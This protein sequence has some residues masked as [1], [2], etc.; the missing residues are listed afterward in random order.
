VSRV[1]RLGRWTNLV[2]A[3]VL[4]FAVWVLVVL[5]A[6]RSSLKKLWDFSPQAVFTMSPATETLLAELQ[7]QKIKVEFHTFFRPLAGGAPEDPF[8][9][10]RWQILSRLQQLTADLLREYAFL[11]GESVRVKHH[12]LQRP[13][14]ETR[15]AATKYFPTGD[16]YDMVVV[17]AGGRHKR[18]SL[19]GDLGFIDNPAWSRQ[20]KPGAPN[21]ELPTLK[22][23]KGEEALS[24]ALKSLLAQGKPVLYFLKGNN[25]HALDTDTATGDGYGSFRKAL[26][27]EG[28]ELRDLML[29]PA[30]GVPKDASLVVALEPRFEFSPR[31]AELLFAYLRRGGRLFLNY[32]YVDVD[33]WNPNGGD[34][35]RMLGYEVDNRPVLHLVPTEDGTGRGGTPEVQNL[36]IQDWAVRDGKGPGVLHGLNHMQPITRPLVMEGRVPQLMEARALLLNPHPPQDVTHEELLRTGPRA[37]LGT[38]GQNGQVLFQ[39][40][41]SPAAFG[42]RLLGA[43]ITVES[44]APANGSPPTNG[45]A[46]PKKVTGEAVILTAAAFFN[47]R[48]RFNGDL[49]LN[50]VDWLTERKELVTVR[51]SRYEARNLKVSDEQLGRIRLL[52]VW[53]VPLLFAVVGFAVRY[54]RSRAR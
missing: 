36:S 21:T 47:L 52:L 38:P 31:E 28:C 48:Q 32:S 11:G 2:F 34:L 29:A 13:N 22:D 44:E 18:L 39:P 50:I 10:Q 23:Y 33:G 43:V 42:S 53:G 14:N 19:E 7:K 16:P 25:E 49:G 41:S 46:E 54:R 1:R 20:K 24:S 51:G 26:E 12:D 35:G 15:D 30:D 3:G 4:M 37:W 17:V 27:A 8:E 45:G 6:S 40:P 5:A 9:R